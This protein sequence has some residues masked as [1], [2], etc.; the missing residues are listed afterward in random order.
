[1]LTREGRTTPTGPWGAI[2]PVTPNEGAV[3]CRQALP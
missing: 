3:F 2:V 1:M